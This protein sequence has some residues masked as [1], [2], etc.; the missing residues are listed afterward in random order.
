[1]YREVEQGFGIFE[2]VGRITLEGFRL[3]WLTTL[4]RM[5]FIEN[6]S[7]LPLF[8]LCAA[9]IWALWTTGGEPK[10]LEI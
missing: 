9:A 7:V 3:P 10:K 5:G 4:E 2:A 6:A 1:M 8:L